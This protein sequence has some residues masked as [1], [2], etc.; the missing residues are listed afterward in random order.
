MSRHKLKFDTLPDRFAICRLSPDAPIPHWANRGV[1]VSIT[2]TADELSIICP[3]TA[4]P[5]DLNADPEWICFKLE[6]P[7]SF[8]QTGVLT[9]FVQPL[10][11]NAIPIFVLSTYDTDYILIKE[12]FSEL[13]FEILR[14]AGHQLNR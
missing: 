13:A 6:G 11:D 2:R 10:S 1:F 7:I 3:A 12:A 5:A 4:V 14:Q 8:T 9:S